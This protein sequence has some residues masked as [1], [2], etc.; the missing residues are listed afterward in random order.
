MTQVLDDPEAPDLDRRHRRRVWAAVIVLVVVPLLVVGG[1]AMWFWWQLDPPG[2]AGSAVQV[3]VDDGWSVSRIGDELVDRDVIGSSVVWNV[4]TRLKDRK[5]F[6]A[7]TY[8]LRKDMG[9][10]NA[11]SALEAGPEDRLH[12]ARGAARAVD[13]GGRAAGRRPAPGPDRGRV[14]RRGAQWRQA[15]EVPA[16]GRHVARRAAVAGHLPRRRHRRRDRRARLDGERVRE[17]RRRARP[18]ERDHRRA[19]AVRDPHG[20]VV[21]RGRG[22]GRRGPAADRVGDLQPAA[23]GDAAPDRRDRALR[24]RR[25][26]QADDHPSRPRPRT[27]PTTRT[28]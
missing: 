18:R 28:R 15:V 3:R 4:Y 25:S 14:P 21:D 9:V 2:Q 23:H 19:H 13:A 1:S 7:G 10:R 27:R 26:H 22:Q 12:R 11:V 16:R 24:E 20:R 8:A 5:D 17:E 6:Q